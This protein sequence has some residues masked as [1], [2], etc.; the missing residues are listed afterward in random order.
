MRQPITKTSSIESKNISRSGNGKAQPA[1][2]TPVQPKLNSEAGQFSFENDLRLENSSAVGAVQTKP[3][4]SLIGTR[5]QRKSDP[6]SQGESEVESLLESRLN[7]KGGGNPLPAETNEFMGSR[8]GTDFSGVKVHTDNNAVQMNQEV[9]AKAFAHGQNIYFNQ[10]QYNPYSNEGKHLLAHELAHTV[11]QMPNIIRRKT[12]KKNDSRSKNL[13][14]LVDEFNKSGNHLLKGIYENITLIDSIWTDQLPASDKSFFWKKIKHT[15]NYYYYHELDAESNDKVTSLIKTSRDL[16][17]YVPVSDKFKVKL[18]SELNKR[19]P[20]FTQMANEDHLWNLNQVTRAWARTCNVT[21]LAMVLG[22]LGK[23]KSDFK[24][25]WNILLS[26]A[27]FLKP[28]IK[29]DNDLKLERFP[30]FL[31]IVVLYHFSR[32]QGDHLLTIDNRLLDI[33]LFVDAFAESSKKVTHA[34]TL[35]DIA[36]LFGVNKYPGIKGNYK[37]LKSYGGEGGRNLDKSISSLEK[38]IAHLLKA[39]GKKKTPIKSMLLDIKSNKSLE[40]YY[41]YMIKN[42][43]RG[44]KRDLVATLEII[45]L[46]QG[47]INPQKLPKKRVNNLAKKIKTN[48][49]IKDKRHKRDL[50]IALTSKDLRSLSLYETMFKNFL[51]KDLKKK[52]S[53]LRKLYLKRPVLKR[54]VEK[55]GI[56]IESFKENVL[57]FVI[58]LMADGYQFIILRP[59]HYM[60]LVLVNEDTVIMNDPAVAGKYK[61][62]NWTQAFNEGLFNVTISLK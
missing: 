45:D 21:S 50:L 14:F 16:I 35:V 6:D 57:E 39:K 2:Q 43:I 28:E 1:K 51:L 11:Q 9:G 25:N 12:V 55:K 8:F 15:S 61:S 22:A 38:Q 54:K 59:G 13:E 34:K 5:I 36:S 4:A 27:R 23:N 32:K 26:V 44:R 19:S 47:G 30:D 46:I 31:Q 56:N 29:N 40:K 60:T 52:V 53:E 17:N 49:Y 18:H 58:P 42:S 24:G 41:E 37:N 3:L 10:G 48:P 33:L 20:Y 62:Y 7:S